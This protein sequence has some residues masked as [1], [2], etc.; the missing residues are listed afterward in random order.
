M[1]YNACSAREIY[2]YLRM[3]VIAMPLVTKA[4]IFIK[5]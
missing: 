3:E 5:L 4:I 1:V 2:I